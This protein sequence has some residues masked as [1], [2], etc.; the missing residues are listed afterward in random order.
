MSDTKDSDQSNPTGVTVKVGTRMILVHSEN[1]K[2]SI[3]K[4]IES[5]N[6]TGYFTP[7]YNPDQD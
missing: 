3:R 5:G 7:P 2:D 1:D 6:Y 4:A